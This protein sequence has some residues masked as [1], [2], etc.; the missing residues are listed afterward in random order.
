MAVEHIP[1]ATHIVNRGQGDALRTGFEIAQI[2]HADIVVNMDAD[3]QH[4]PE[5]IELLVRPIIDG[6]ADFVMGSRSGQLRGLGR[7]ATPGHRAVLMADKPARPR[8]HHRL[9][10]RLP[11]NPGRRHPQTAPAGGPLQHCGADPRGD[12][13]GPSHPRGAGLHPQTLAGRE[14]EAE[15]TRLPIGLSPRHR[16]NLAAVTNPPSARALL[17]NE[18][19]MCSEPATRQ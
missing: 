11:R 4:Q 18:A 17:A 12:E 6:E 10:E 7:R 16:A 19:S 2:E 15:A 9:H 5:E 3:G 1:V 13:E 14:Q 8:P